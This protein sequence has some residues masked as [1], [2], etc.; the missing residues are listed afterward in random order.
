[1]NQIDEAIE[2]LTQAKAIYAANAA[3][4]E[5]KTLLEE[6]LEIIEKA[7]DDDGAINPVP[8]TDN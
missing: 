5:V 4:P 2:K 7:L 3:A 1:M 8:V 6:A